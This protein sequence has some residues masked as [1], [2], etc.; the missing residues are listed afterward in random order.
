MD[1]RLNPVC[2]R[3]FTLIELVVV[4]VIVAVIVSIG[5][6]VGPRVLGSS[7]V[8]STQNVLQALDQALTTYSMNG[9]KRFPAYYKDRQ[10][11]SFPIIDAT[12]GPGAP[13]QPTIALAMAEMER[14]P[15]AAEL[16]RSI[17][18]RFL[19]RSAVAFG[20]DTVDYAPPQAAPGGGEVGNAMPV[21]LDAWGRPIR[22]VHPEFH[23]TYGD[24]T[25]PALSATTGAGSTAFIRSNAP[26]AGGI[27]IA[28]GGRAVSGRPYFYS[29]G[30]DGDPGTLEDNLYSQRPVFPA[31][32][33]QI[34]PPQ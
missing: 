5:L 21:V 32:N 33:A 2:G 1:K 20:A 10:G 13:A 15:R 18:S 25:D 8:R 23:G 26:V 29:T 27:A 4:F 17:P 11:R 22:I 9:E 12:T 30:P 7:K 34:L 19:S 16:L 28:D 3:A 6:S 24:G 31:Q 14:E